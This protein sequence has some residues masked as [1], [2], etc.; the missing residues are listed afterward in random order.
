MKPVPVIIEDIIDKVTNKNLHPDQK[1]HYVTTL[2]NV[3]E[4]AQKA[5]VS[6]E[7]HRKSY[8]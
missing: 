1:Q 3:V 8:K 5:L 6:Y 2:Q 4:E 7:L